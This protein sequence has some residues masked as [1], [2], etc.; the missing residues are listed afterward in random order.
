[1]NERPC[2]RVFIES[3]VLDGHSIPLRSGVW[4]FG[5]KPIPKGGSIPTKQWICSPLKLVAVTSDGRGGHFGRLLS[6]KNTL[7]IWCQWGMPMELLS[8]S[9][10]G[11]RAELLSM[12]VEID[13]TAHKLLG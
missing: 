13:P 11:L 7:G 1:E 3:V 8:G 9:G 10:E 2:F 12:G 6:F 5:N 4:F